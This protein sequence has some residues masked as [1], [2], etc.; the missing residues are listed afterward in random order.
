VRRKAGEGVIHNRRLSTTGALMVK[1]VTTF[2]LGTLFFAGLGRAEEQRDFRSDKPPFLADRLLAKGLDCRAC[3]TE[4]GKKATG[5]ACLKCHGSFEEVAKRTR[6]MDPNPHANHSTDYDPDCT[7][8]H[9]GHKANEVYCVKC[10]P[11]RTLQ[12]KPAAK[13]K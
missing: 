1:A 7:R 8:C 9:H 5:E 6:D 10:H 13:D 11:G 4:P 12:R 3:H 2:F